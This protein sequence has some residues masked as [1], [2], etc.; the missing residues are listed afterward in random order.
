LCRNIRQRGGE[1]IV[2]RYIQDHPERL[3]FNAI[4]I[5]SE[6]LTEAYPCASNP[7]H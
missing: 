4:S 6:A 5:V 1:A 7:N 2:E 3:Q